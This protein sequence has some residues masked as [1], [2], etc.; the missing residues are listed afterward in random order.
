MNEEPKLSLKS[1]GLPNNTIL[2]FGGKQIPYVT[3]VVTT[4]EVDCLNT[5]EVTVELSSI[6][7]EAYVTFCS[8]SLS[9]QSTTELKKFPKPLLLQLADKIRELATC[10]DPR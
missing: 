10:P 1:D 6:F 3:K 7:A 2:S 5:M 4:H 8:L 9:E